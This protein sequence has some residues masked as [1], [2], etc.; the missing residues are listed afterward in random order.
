MA[1]HP[2]VGAFALDREKGPILCLG[3]LVLD[4][5]NG[6]QIGTRVVREASRWM[7]IAP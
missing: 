5:T 4:R 7:M 2:V 3:S 1:P 6:F